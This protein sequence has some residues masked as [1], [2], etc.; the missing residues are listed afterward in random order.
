MKKKNI[1]LWV[2]GKEIKKRKKKNIKLQKKKT[3]RKKNSLVPRVFC[4]SQNF[5]FFLLSIFPRFNQSINHLNIKNAHTKKKDFKFFFPSRSRLPGMTIFGKK[6]KIYIM[7]WRHETK[8]RLFLFLYCCYR[9]Q[10]KK[11]KPG[12]SILLIIFTKDIVLKGPRSNMPP[13]GEHG[14]DANFEV[15]YQQCPNDSS[16]LWGLL[17]CLHSKNR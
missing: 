5:L 9:L 13:N 6:N 1:L 15:S 10:K 12:G 7:H 14:T 8:T 17:R 4:I 3:Y 16:G 2:V 11:K